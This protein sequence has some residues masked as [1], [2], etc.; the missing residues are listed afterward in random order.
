MAELV[1]EAGLGQRA[2]GLAAEV[3]MVGGDGLVVH[4][5]DEHR[6][7]VV[8]AL[9]WRLASDLRAAKDATTSLLS[10]YIFNIYIY[11]TSI[12]VRTS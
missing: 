5:R 1:V 12:G 3:E 7:R 10:I 11:L 8:R 4:A 6:H 9:G 2:E